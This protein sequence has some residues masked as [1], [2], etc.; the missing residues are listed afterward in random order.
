MGK[1]KKG[2]NEE[3]CYNQ[4][5]QYIRISVT[6]NKP[7][8]IFIPDSLLLIVASATTGRWGPLLHI[9]SRVTPRHNVTYLST[10]IALNWSTTSH[11]T[12]LIRK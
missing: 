3:Y 10:K 2:E 5:R 1:S 12:P 11:A 4:E 6:K 7:Y 8:S 9:P